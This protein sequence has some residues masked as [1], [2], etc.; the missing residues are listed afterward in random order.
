M[1]NRLIA[2]LVMLAAVS[3]SAMA[4]AKM[5]DGNLHWSIA[6]G[7]AQPVGDWSKVAKLGFGAG[8]SADW[9]MNSDWAIRGTVDYTTFSS[10]FAG[11]GNSNIYG[12]SVNFLHHDA[13][14]L[15]YSVGV[16]YAKPSCSGCDGKPSANGMLGWALDDAKMWSIEGGINV[17]FTSG[18]NT[19][20][21]PIGVR[22]AF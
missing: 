17:V 18:S 19:M 1:R 8:V 9:H 7:I 20:W 5:A 22:Y 15:T 16:G 13:T 2:G 10:K 14:K 12:L 11:G 3:G 4:Q 6:G 21:V